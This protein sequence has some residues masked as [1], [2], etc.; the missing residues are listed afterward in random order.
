[1]F[2]LP[3]NFTSFFV[4]FVLKTNRYVFQIDSGKTQ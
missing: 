2:Y 1:M 3:A 4:I